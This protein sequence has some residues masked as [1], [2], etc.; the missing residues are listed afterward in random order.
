MPFV[1]GINTF[2][3]ASAPDLQQEEV[4]MLSEQDMR[5]LCIDYGLPMFVMENITLKDRIVEKKT[6]L[7]LLFTRFS[8][9]WIMAY[10][11]MKGGEKD[12]QKTP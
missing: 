4:V 1:D 8:G 2:A 12:G 7:S 9:I 6:D 5:H 11:D 10:E 3:A